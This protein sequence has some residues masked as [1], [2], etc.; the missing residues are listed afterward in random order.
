MAY[1][2]KCYDLAQAFLEDHPNLNTELRRDMLAQ[3]IQTTIDDYI[4][5]EHE[6]YEPSDSA[7]IGN[8]ADDLRHQQ[9]EAMKLK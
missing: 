4:V 8:T 5:C 6:N 7:P 3:V 9:T 1:D 2:P